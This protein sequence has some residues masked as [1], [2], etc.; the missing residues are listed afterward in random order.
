MEYSAVTQ[1]RPVLR[2]QPGT[3]CSMVALVSTRVL[4]KETRTEPSAVWTNP[5]VRV[6]GRSCAGVRPPGRKNS[7][8]PFIEGLYGRLERGRGRSGSGSEPGKQSISNPDREL[9]DITLK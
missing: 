7:E 8:R 1:P 4:P 5:G 2:S 9:I 3:P 6:R